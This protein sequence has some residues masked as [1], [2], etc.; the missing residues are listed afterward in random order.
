MSEAFSHRIEVRY[1]ECDMQGVVFNAHYHAYCDD[2]VEHWM[3]HLGM[4]EVA[5]DWD[6]ML[7]K[8][9]IEWTSAARYGDVVDIACR[10]G[11]VGNTSFSV[12]MD[13]AVASGPSGPLSGEGSRPVFRTE[14]V[15]VGVRK[16]TVETIPVPTEIRERLGAPA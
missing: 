5:G 14:I 13:G 12:V 2:A 7:K 3:K 11:K 6:F 4:R 9:T 16:G 10:V 15:Y 8:S 1:G